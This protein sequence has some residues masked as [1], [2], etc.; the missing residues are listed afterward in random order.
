MRERLVLLAVAAITACSPAATGPTHEFTI[1]IE[2]G[3]EVALTTGGPKY[4]GEIFAYERITVLRPDPDVEESFLYS[5]EWMTTSDDGR[6]FVGDMGD[7]Q[8][9][10]FSPG[11][12]YL[13]RIGQEGQ[14][15]GEFQNVVWVDVEEDVLWVTDHPFRKHAFE[16]DGTFIETISLPLPARSLIRDGRWWR[17]ADGR[18]VIYNIRPRDLG[19]GEARAE[20]FV[21][22]A[23]GEVGA[24]AATPTVVATEY[25]EQAEEGSR[26]VPLTRQF[27]GRPW[28][29]FSPRFGFF[30]TNPP[31]PEVLVY[32][33]DANLRRRYRVDIPPQ[34][35]TDED[36]AKVREAL[37]QMLRR[38]EERQRE[39][40]LE[41]ARVQL[42]NPRYADPKHYWD[43]PIL[44]DKGFAWILIPEPLVYPRPV[45]RFVV[46]SPEG[47]YLGIT[48]PPEWPQPV[49]GKLLANWEDPQDGQEYPVVY[50]IVPIVDGLVY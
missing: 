23:D 37:E 7:N 20:M 17:L 2:D 31:E 11:G 49:R 22:G 19:R 41:R 1:T 9:V 35:I 36:R 21:V 13:Y 5:P 33:D 25:L 18:F 48:T 4:D 10:V 42:A 12:D 16:L 8:V 29:D 24:H 30:L 28:G 6:I 3:V 14:G 46:F 27:A 40:D 50:R 26:P 47:E 34:A 39:L 32:D 43:R 15:P 44:D 38:A 45:H